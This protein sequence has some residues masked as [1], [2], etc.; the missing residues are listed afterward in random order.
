MMIENRENALEFGLTHIFPAAFF[1]T[2]NEKTGPIVVT[3]SPTE[4]VD[5]AAEGAIKL[6]AGLSTNQIIEHG[7]I[8]GSTPWDIPSGEMHWIAF[9]RVNQIARG[10]VE[11][12]ALGIVAKQNLLL[13]RPSFNQA[14]LGILLGGM[15]SYLNVLNEDDVDIT[16]EP[17]FQ[18]RNFSTLSLIQEVLDELRVMSCEVLAAYVNNRI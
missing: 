16:T 4:H 17:F 15:N 13:A 8:T 12:H 10:G 6:M 11:I 3:S 14:V 18:D 2:A 7:Y 9:S 5:L 1:F